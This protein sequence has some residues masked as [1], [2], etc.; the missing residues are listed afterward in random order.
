[1]LTSW[2]LMVG[3][4]DAGIKRELPRQHQLTGLPLQP[5]TSPGTLFLFCLVAPGSSLV[6][7]RR[8][9]EGPSSPTRDGS[10]SHPQA[11]P[12]SR[13][14]IGELLV[15]LASGRKDIP[16]IFHGRRRWTPNGRRTGNRK[17]SPCSKP[18]VVPPGGY[19]EET[20]SCTC[21]L[22]I[23]H[24]PSRWLNGHT[25]SQQDVSIVT[26][27]AYAVMPRSRNQGLWTKWVSD[28]ILTGQA[29][30]CLL[31]DP[32]RVKPDGT[33]VIAEHR[34]TTTT[35]MEEQAKIFQCLV[36]PVGT[37][38]AIVSKQVG[39]LTPAAGWIT[40]LKE[41]LYRAASGSIFRGCIFFYFC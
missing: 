12:G 25:N 10:K 40:D 15:P 6:R 5:W 30:L 36:T 39:E 37:D 2:C 24:H 32:L 26:I 8:T 35:R 17:S 4:S 18:D 14:D 21:R 33:A 23:C 19:R 3:N 13:L 16:E 7:D 1:M 27:K 34:A 38:G 41:A 11:R 9:A 20:V 22:Y 29:S 31:L 28:E